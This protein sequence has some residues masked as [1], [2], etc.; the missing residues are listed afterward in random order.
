MSACIIYRHIVEFWAAGESS[1]AILSIARYDPLI[2]A[3][4]TIIFTT[5]CR[6]HVCV[7][8]AHTRAPHNNCSARRRSVWFRSKSAPET[9]KQ[10]Y[11]PNQST[12]GCPVLFS[13]HPYVW[14]ERARL[15][16]CPIF[17]RNH[18]VLR[19]CTFRAQLI[20]HST[21]GVIFLGA[22][23]S[24]L[25]VARIYTRTVLFGFFTLNFVSGGEIWF[26]RCRVRP[27]VFN[28]WTIQM[29]NSTSVV[30]IQIILC[31]S[32]VNYICS[33]R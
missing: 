18:S 24:W 4:A 30:H 3:S 13:L 28:Y 9:T 20:L 10:P 1:S 11:I 16:G 12:W 26:C 33:R 17:R 23:P 31:V 5:V 29:L 21:S 32:H 22:D 15:C 14:F 2:A 27:H 7:C 25:P 6:M 19:R 8:I